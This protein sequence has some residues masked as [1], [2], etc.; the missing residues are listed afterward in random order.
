M[1]KKRKV[2]GVKPKLNNTG[3]QWEKKADKGS[4]L[5]MGKIKMQRNF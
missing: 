4:F 1:A 2:K 5:N 3:L